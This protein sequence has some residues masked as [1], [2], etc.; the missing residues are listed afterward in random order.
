M[1]TGNPPASHL[2]KAQ[3]RERWWDLQGNRGQRGDT[4]GCDYSSQ[5]G[6]GRVVL[7]LLHP[8]AAWRAWRGLVLERLTWHCG[9]AGE[10]RRQAL[11]GRWP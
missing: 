2:P 4:E 8:L 3:N 5:G 9:C 10:G 11:R 7:N 6:D 1:N